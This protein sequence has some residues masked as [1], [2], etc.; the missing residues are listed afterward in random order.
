MKKKG[1]I[2]RKRIIIYYV[3]A[4]VLPCLILGML[5]LRGIKNDQ[6]I[7]ER[8]QRRN[9]SETSQQIIRETDAYLSSIE[10]NFAKIIESTAIPRKTIFTDSALSRFCS[11]HQAVEGIFF[12]SRNN[13]L[14]LLNEG[15]IY[16]PDDFL[17]APGVT[18]SHNIQNILDKGWQFEFRENDYRKALEYYQTFLPD[19][20][21]EQSGGEILNSLARLQK[22]M[23]LEDEAIKTYEIIWNSYPQYF[24][25]NK[26]PSGAVAL[27]EK[28]L[29]YLIKKDTI[30]ALKAVHL[31]MNQM[32]KP[33]WELGYSTYT[34][35]LSKIYEIISPFKNFHNEET[36]AYLERVKALKD[37]LSI[38]EK[39]TEYLLSFL[40]KSEKQFVNKGPYLVNNNNRYKIQINGESYLY[41]LAQANDYGQWGLIMDPEYILKKIVYGS[42]FKHAEES[43]FSW[44]VTDINGG[45]LVRSENISEN[46]MPV[47]TVFPSNLPSWTL[48]LFPAETGLFAS[49]FRPGKSL[50]FYIFIAIVVILACGLF[51]TLQT[52]NNELNLSRMKSYF[53]ST[54]S[55]EFKSPLTSIRQM[56]EM[57]VRNRVPSI[58]RKQ[59]YYSTIL[60]QSERLS[61]LI[62]NI[63]DF[64]KMEEGHKV[65]HFEKAD[66]VPVVRDIVDLFRELKVSQGFQIN[67]EVP[68]TLPLIV[69]D[70]ESVEQVI[71]NLIDNA[72]KYSHESKTIDVQLFS[73]LS[74]I[75][76]S[77]G[78][79]GVGIRKE[80]QEKI[81]SRFY[82]AG[83]EL[84]QNVKGSG[85]GLAI[86]KQIIE[87]HHGEITVESSPGKGSVFKAKL[88]IS[89]I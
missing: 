63:L 78:D 74:N 69:F 5:A 17:T 70:R 55:H 65:F 47:Y 81:F 24:I 79:Y 49:L 23:K 84:T 32:Q 36:G 29:L 86:V 48:T 3:L 59:K 45:L 57:L 19:V 2:K 13:D 72:C 75:I 61:H 9:L 4:I 30:S 35:L 16:V 1:E 88:P 12:I 25:Q 68:E 73:T 42:I 77:V 38:S 37:S 43:V 33:K 21:G 53:M 46:T 10:K 60:Q 40:G 76:I 34:N 56:A 6:A 62:D 54:V 51:F 15:M 27:L 18:G 82:R 41:Y 71:Y 7:E 44:E 11:Q 28:S 50:F 8:E 67:L 89:Q 14:L 52:I 22:K 39:H 80:D 85:I 58:D 83:E 87:A 20:T 26:I 31:L 66:I 64:T